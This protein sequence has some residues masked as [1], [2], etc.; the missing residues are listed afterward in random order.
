MAVPFCCCA[1]TDGGRTA[2][3]WEVARGCLAGEQRASDCSRPSQNSTRKSRDETEISRWVL[4]LI[5][6]RSRLARN[7]DNRAATIMAVCEKV[8]IVRLRM[9]LLSSLGYILFSDPGQILKRQSHKLKKA[10]LT[11]L[12]ILPHLE[13]TNY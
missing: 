7:E 5:V 12:A 6:N 10:F 13:R 9:F 1:S 11:Q 3:T 4:R 8:K 2:F